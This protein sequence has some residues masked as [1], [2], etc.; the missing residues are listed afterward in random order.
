ML[1]KNNEEG[2]PIEGSEGM[3]LQNLDNLS[4]PRT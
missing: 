4:S 1:I 2:E 3:A